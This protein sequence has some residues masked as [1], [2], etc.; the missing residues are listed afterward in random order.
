MVATRDILVYKSGRTLLGKGF[1]SMYRDYLYREGKLQPTI[2]VQR[3]VSE[4]GFTEGTELDYGYHSC[5]SVQSLRDRNDL[6]GNFTQRLMIIPKGTVCYYDES[7]DEYLS[8][9]IK[10][11]GEPTRWNKFLS[12]IGLFPN[13]NR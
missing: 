2:R 6:Y 1:T 12:K 13:S 10:Y 3:S 7:R 5:G 8:E 4:E 11:I 9:T